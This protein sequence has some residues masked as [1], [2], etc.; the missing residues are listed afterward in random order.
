MGVGKST[1]V[2]VSF[3]HSDSFYYAGEEV[4]GIV[5]YHNTHKTLHVKSIFI[6]FIGEFCYT[7]PYTH[8]YPNEADYSNIEQRPVHHRI[9]FINNRFPVIHPEANQD[10]VILERGEYSWPF[11]FTLPQS[12]P[13]SSSPSTTSYPY[14]RYYARIVVGK[15]RY[16]RTMK[17]IYPLTVFPNVN[18]FHTN[19]GRQPVLLSSRNRKNL[20]VKLYL[21]Q[22]GILPGQNISL[23]IDLQNPKRLKIQRIEATLIQHRQVALDHHAETIFQKNLPNMANFD[24]AELHQTFDLLVPS[25]HLPPTYTCKVKCHSASIRTNIYYE[26][27]LEIKV[28]DV[29]CN[30]K[31]NIPIIIATESL[32]DR[33][34][35][36][37]N[38]YTDM[39][40]PYSA[41]LEETDILPSYE[42][43]IKNCKLE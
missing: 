4:T 18:L 29:L 28:D 25:N 30:M 20:K 32:P 11:Q 22:R 37:N 12:L 42:F 15:S 6:D 40:I 24:K 16:Q 5:S 33:Y 31:F 35:I 9:P 7:T 39:P 38:N 19:D 36:G 17:P 10:E 13:P 8:Q 21:D 3:N 26:L 27:K 14:V 23:H 2:N 1:T 43:A 41:V 34:Q